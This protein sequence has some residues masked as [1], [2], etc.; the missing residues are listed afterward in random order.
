[1]KATDLLKKQHKKVKD[2]LTEM[3]EA[4]KV[5]V[6]KLRQVADELVAHMVIEEHLFYPAV[7]KVDKDIVIESFEEHA[8]ARF[9][10]T[11]A[12]AAK[13]EDQTARVKVL[14][15]LIE[16]HVKEE[17]DELFPKVDRALTSTA[18]ESLGTKMEVMFKK[19]VAEGRTS[20]VT[21]EKV[22]KNGPGTKRAA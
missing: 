11:R 15:E 4:P 14:K 22:S 18:N 2:A 19:A 20:L 12:L 8:V 21:K 13:G 16:H 6:K 10:L 7:K 1:M 3:S 17:E 9:E 5:D